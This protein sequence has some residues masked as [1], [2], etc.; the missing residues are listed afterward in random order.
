MVEEETVASLELVPPISVISPWCFQASQ[1]LNVL[2]NCIFI[3]KILVIILCNFNL[4]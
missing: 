2:Q 1:N 4:L 3:K